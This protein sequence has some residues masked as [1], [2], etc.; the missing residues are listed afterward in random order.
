M[1]YQDIEMLIAEAHEAKL[2]K[3]LLEAKLYGYGGIRHDELEMICAMFG[4]R[5]GADAA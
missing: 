2:L 3:Q 4:I 1:E 5:R